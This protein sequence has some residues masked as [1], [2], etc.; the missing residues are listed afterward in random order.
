MEKLGKLLS[1][2]KFAVSD[3]AW[4]TEFV[5]L[6]LKPGEAPEKWNLEHPDRVRSVA[7]SYVQAGSEIILTN[8]FG[9]NGFKLKKAGVDGGWDR[10]NSEGCRQ[11]RLAGAGKALVFASI[12]PT[13]EFLEPLGDLTGTQM[14]DC[15]VSQ[16]KA[17]LEGAP[18]G[19]VIETMIDLNEALAALKAVK[20]V[21]SLPVVVS[22]TYQKTR[23]GYATV[24]GVTP[25]KACEALDAA[26]ADVIGSNC[27]NGIDDMIGLT[28]ILKSR[29][30]KPLWVKANAGQ[31]KLVNG[32][33]V[34][35][36][37]PEYMASRVAELVA[38]GAKII[39]GCCGTTPEHIR[40][41][42]QSRSGI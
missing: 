32:E 1:A 38:S 28:R 26:G 39:G 20:Q 14:V 18:D 41:I 12:G 35:G 40:R 30:E 29:T 3:G 4:G 33:T 19:F 37:T 31:P 5:R 21:C 16:A 9:A 8:T 27:G 15:F 17:I 22:L 34:Y 6:G 7:A 2:G 25:E 23:Q 11:S 24:M 42:V 36:E 10:I 13:G